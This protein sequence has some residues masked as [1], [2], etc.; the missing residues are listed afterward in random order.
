MKTIIYS[1]ALFICN[2]YFLNAQ[3]LLS[4]DSSATSEHQLKV[5]GKT[6]SYTATVGTQP[7]WDKTGKEVAYLF[8]T[9]YQ[10]QGVSNLEQRPLV[11]SFNGGPGSASIWMHIAYT[12]P[13]VLNIDEEG[14]PLQPYGVKDNP[15]SILDVADI[16]Y[17]DPVNTGYSRITDKEADRSQ[18]FGVNSDIDYLSEWV[19]TFVNRQKR[20]A[21]P[22][23]L[24]GES[25]GTTRVSGMANR[26]QESHWMFFNGVILVSPTDLGI[27][28]EGPVQAA[29]YLPYYTATAW[30][31]KQLDPSLQS[32][33]LEEILPE[34]ELF[35]RKELVPALM[36]GGFMD[37]AEKERLAKQMAH[38]SGLS[39]KVILEHNLMVPTSFF[40]KDL[41]RDEGLTVGRLDSRYKGIDR[42]D[43]G[44]RFDHD[45][46]LSSWNHAFAPAF[47]HYMNHKLQ[48]N[49]DIEYN[50]F[51]PVHPWDRSGD[52]TGENLRAAMAQNPYLNVMIQSGYYDGGTDYFNAKY[53]MWQMDPSGKLK[54][55]LLWKGYRSGHM[56]YL[57]EE[58]L[59]NA[60]EDIRQF[61]LNSLPEDSQAAK[62]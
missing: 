54:D 47:N 32:K 27:D 30:Y 24:I 23:F 53:S 57:R 46:A 7:V 41:L 40:W 43:K 19:R 34:V 61:I 11:I 48:F 33:D 50:L 3:Q 9:Y 18:F 1:I 4:S 51:G 13:V 55:R 22:K 60:N 45:P 56:M 8:Y 31:H 10:R 58:D 26:L 14:Y 37:S 59:A 5:N 35:T 15:H 17:I 6:I 39:Q 36:M 62:Y 28:R 16:V 29:N 20:W 38:Y 52:R 2:L 44:D 49:T 21:S 12:G 25:Y 42:A